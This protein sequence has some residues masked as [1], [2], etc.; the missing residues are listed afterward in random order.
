MPRE[1][2]KSVTISEGHHEKAEKIRDRLKKHS[3][4]GVVEDLI[5]EETEQIGGA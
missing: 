1:G 4:S 2:Y 5:D 3:V